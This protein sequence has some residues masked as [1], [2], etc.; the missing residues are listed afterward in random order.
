MGL[1]YFDYRVITRHQNLCFCNIMFN[2]TKQMHCKTCSVV[3][4]K[5]NSFDD[6]FPTLCFYFSS[7]C[8]DCCIAC[9][10]NDLLYFFFLLLSCLL[11]LI[12]F[13]DFLK[14]CT[15]YSFFFSISIGI[16][17]CNY[18]NYD[19]SDPLTGTL[20]CLLYSNGVSLRGLLQVSNM[21]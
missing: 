19:F 18:W 7:F 17:L 2:W 21:R 14:I 5:L 8:C 10:T 12:R 3:Y 4:A 1:L 16:M 6:Y 13:R 9:L 11:V 20:S 15:L